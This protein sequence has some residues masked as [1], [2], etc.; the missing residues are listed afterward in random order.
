MNCVYRPIRAFV[1]ILCLVIMLAF[2]TGSF[3]LSA[4]TPQSN[5]KYTYY[6]VKEKDTV[7]SIA[8]KYGLKEQDIY[9][10]NPGTEMG[11]RI[12]QSLKI[13]Q[14][15]PALPNT[16]GHNAPPHMGTHTVASGETLFAIARK[17]NISPAVLKQYNPDIDPDVL[18]P[19]MEIR[20][21]LPDGTPLSQ[22]SSNIMVT[23]EQMERLKIA[24]LLPMDAEKG[25]P[26]RYVRFYE[27]FLMGV[28][29][30]KRK[31]ISVEL[32]VYCTPNEASFQKVIHSGSLSNRDLII[33]GQ[34]NSQVEL[35]ARYASDRGMVYVSPFISVSMP[36]RGYSSN[37][38]KLNPTQSDLF[39]YI[40]AAFRSKFSNYS[41][42]IVSTASHNHNHFI[43][44]LKTTFTESHIPFAEVALE[45]ISAQAIEVA[46]K[47]KNVVLI[48]DDSS[49]EVLRVLLDK[50]DNSPS[51]N[52][53]ITLFGYPQW[54][55]YNKAML[56]QLGKYNGTI[57]SSFF[58]YEEDAPTQNFV[59]NYYGWFSKEIDSTY[60]KFSLLGYDA[61]RYFIGA[62]A[63][64]GGAFTNMP[65]QVPSDG[66][67]TDFIFRKA[68]GEEAYSNVNLF[69]IS[70]SNDGK[71]K[72]TKVVY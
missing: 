65:A 27:G 31:G 26:E 22:V 59:N 67:Q 32:D 13:P 53:T 61:S 29:N 7:Y 8:R 3:C 14:P 66:L 36:K 71:A 58:F 46:S 60:P 68:Q 4:Q 69:F 21:A 45:S 18:K 15:T 9:R 28:Y 25:T 72:R 23:S 1:E 30:A 24:L 56:T 17:Y 64:Y 47:K 42:V 50:L 16:I 35:L 44:H 38:F 10:L 54:Q 48:P 43:H 52:R 49:P 5:A 57:Y 39:P 63:H 34:S 19:G 20:I 6:E 11:I 40:S 41:P 55:S 51:K 12:G 2:S 70:F 62:L 37:T 33:G